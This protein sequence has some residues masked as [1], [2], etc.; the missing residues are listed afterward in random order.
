[1]FCVPQD[2]KK[3]TT[4]SRNVDKS[5]NRNEDDALVSSMSFNT[6]CYVSFLVCNVY[7]SCNFSTMPQPTYNLLVTSPWLA[8]HIKREL[9][10]EVPPMSS[11]PVYVNTSSGGSSSSSGSSSP[12]V[13]S[14][15]QQ[16]ENL[17]GYVPM[18][19]H[20]RQT[21][22]VVSGQSQ[23]FVR[24]QQQQSTEQQQQQ[25]IRNRPQ[26]P[27]PLSSRSPPLVQRSGTL[28]PPYVSNN[29]Y[30]DPDRRALPEVPEVS[31]LELFLLEFIVVVWNLSSSLN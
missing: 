9:I 24:S 25:Q 16:H 4:L 21:P 19:F 5:G 15:Q 20:P 13:S 7:F 2:N 8:K 23:S 26:L 30:E 1:M 28:P 3:A 11:D 27:L 29:L 18:I 22:V 12:A 17:D 10:C 31:S 6:A 14:Q